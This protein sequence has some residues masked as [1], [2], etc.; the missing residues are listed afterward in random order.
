M[1]VA[2]LTKKKLKNRSRQ[3][4]SRFAEED[5]DMAIVS[6]LENEPWQPD[7][8]LER[9]DKINNSNNNISSISNGQSSFPS[10]TSLA[11][12]AT[13]ITSSPSNPIAIDTI[14]GGGG[15]QSSGFQGVIPVIIKSP[16][17]VITTTD[18]DYV[19]SIFEDHAHKI[20]G[21][22][23]YLQQTHQQQQLLQQQQHEM[24]M[25]MQMQLQLQYQ[26]PAHLQNNGFNTTT[27]ATT[28]HG[29][30]RKQTPQH[31]RNSFHGHSGSSL[32]TMEEH[33]ML[34][35][36]T[37]SSFEPNTEMDSSGEKTMT[38]TEEVIESLQSLKNLTMLALD[39]LLQ[40]VVSGVTASDPVHNPDE[41]TL[42][43]RALIRRNSIPLLD[44]VGQDQQSTQKQQQQHQLKND[45]SDAI[46]SS[47][48]GNEI[49]S[50]DIHRPIQ[51]SISD[52]P[53]AGLAAS[54]FERLDELTRKVD[55]LAAAAAANNEQL[56]QLSSNDIASYPAGLRDTR[57]GTLG[58]PQR[59]QER[60]AVPQHHQQQVQ[61]DGSQIFESQEYQLACAL[62]AMLACIYRILNQM[63]EPRMPQRTESMDSGLDQASK[64]WKRLSSNNFVRNPLRPSIPSS[65]SSP[66]TLSALQNRESFPFGKDSTFMTT[67]PSSSSS[68][69]SS[70][71]KRTL[72]GTDSSNN[73]NNNSSGTTGFIQSINKQVRTLRSRRTQSTSLIEVGNNSK[74]LQGKILEGLGLGSSNNSR[75]QNFLRPDHA[76]QKEKAENLE[77]E[78]SEL[79][80]LMDE[81][82]ELWRFVECLNDSNNEGSPST[83]PQTVVETT[84]NDESSPFH[85]RNQIQQ[86]TI[87]VSSMTTDAPFI[88][89]NFDQQTLGMGFSTEELPLYE[90]TAP[91]YKLSEKS[92][93]TEAS[94]RTNSDST[95]RRVSSG[96]LLNG[97]AGLDDEK[98]RFDLSNVMSAIERLSKVAPRLDNQRV[99]LTTSQKRQ[100]AQA[101]V[102][103]TIERLSDDHGLSSPSLSSVS[104][105]QKQRQLASE[106]NR[107]L[108]KLVNQIVESAA[109]ATSYATQRAE[110]SPRQQ[111]KLE[112]ARVG[113]KIE[114]SERL[115]M[116]DQDWQSPEN[117]L[118][119]DMTRLTN[120]LY[121]QSASSKAFATQRYTLTEDKARNMALQGIISKI[122]RVSGRRL[123]NQDALPPNLSKSKNTTSASAPVSV[124]TAMMEKREREKFSFDGSGSTRTRELHDMI[125]QV[126]DSGGG[127]TR[128]SVL[129]AQRA[130]F[131]PGK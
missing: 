124:A 117:V 49:Y 51:R 26:M 82:G 101:S 10:Q 66:T 100:L 21:I 79:D 1:A 80:K 91:Q 83:E 94:N 89:Q 2:M 29:I 39:G 46:S 120:A 118:L 11:A 50:D 90:D 58:I 130:Q 68:L 56:R 52:T 41:T 25:Q 67:L 72:K 128:K 71:E 16:S 43:A 98:T 76:A 85:D 40:Q 32:F 87:S 57:L 31:Y 15:L 114:R 4:Q 63:Q 77:M 22:E 113:S 3:R 104:A 19:E 88:V 33:P 42:Q 86:Q 5:E 127:P 107:D 73:N 95:Q 8:L 81:M 126:I 97:I 7:L 48:N 108:N 84:G 9:S 92:E 105:Q 24:Q 20:P 121:Q 12:A 99:Q 122:E 18:S 123:N 27:T 109:K 44:L 111:W 70:P 59:Q 110:F 93:V 131:S 38:D 65:T 62:A 106:K 6:Q 36:R 78:W 34:Q 116:S 102:A 119:K 13:T 30:T 35:S 14:N 55:Q 54:S 125:N 129:A 61:I 115:R 74:S 64:L 45:F 28:T 69:P 23:E 47:V 60:L 75:N 17:S 37:L 112:G 96:T 53:I 103:H